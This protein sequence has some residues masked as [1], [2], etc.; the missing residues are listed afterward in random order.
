MRLAAM[1]KRDVQHRAFCLRAAGVRFIAFE[2]TCTD[3]LFRECFFSSRTSC[4][5]HARRL[6]ALAI[7]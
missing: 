7:R 5:V 3:V 2:I 1:A 6:V 4:F